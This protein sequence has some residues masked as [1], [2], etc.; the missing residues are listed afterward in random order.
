MKEFLQ[1]EKELSLDAVVQVTERKIRKQGKPVMIVSDID[2]TLTHTHV[3]SVEHNTHIPQFSPDMVAATQNLPRP[4]VLATGRPMHDPAVLATWRQLS[5][6][7]T[8]LIVENGGIIFH[9]PQFEIS[10]KAGNPEKLAEVKES[11]SEQISLLREQNIIQDE[12]EVIFD[13]NR[14]TS[15]EVR[16]QNIAT[17]KGNAATHKEVAKHIQ[18]ILLPHNLIAVTSG[19]SVSIHAPDIQKGETAVHALFNISPLNKFHLN[20]KDVFLITLGD[21]ENDFSLFDIADLGIGVS[22]LTLGHSDLTCVHG[23]EVS[24]EIIK[25]VGEIGI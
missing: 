10:P 22:A 14:K 21:N 7:F 16:I 1:P 4:L 17:K 23:A 11:L 19:S 12:E 15:I 13:T 25:K 20:R 24:L 8:P 6:K 18:H 3:F 2:D 5:G 9:P